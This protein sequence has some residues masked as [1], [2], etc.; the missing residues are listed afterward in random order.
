VLEHAGI[1][2]GEHHQAGAPDL[3]REPGGQIAGAAGDVERLA[4]R[5][6]PVSDNANCFQSL[7]APPDISRS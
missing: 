7:C 5:L 1:D 6:S 2:V 4:A 3:A